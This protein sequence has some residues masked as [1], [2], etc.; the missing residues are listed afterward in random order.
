MQ[1]GSAQSCLDAAA[2]KHLINL[3]QDNPLR[4]FLDTLCIGVIGWPL[5]LGCTGAEQHASAARAALLHRTSVATSK[6]RTG[7]SCA[8]R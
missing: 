2:L 4:A 1:V 3:L 7:K 6:I 8:E 5:A